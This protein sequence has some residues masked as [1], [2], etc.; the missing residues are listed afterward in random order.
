MQV[1]IDTEKYP[2][3]A[4]RFGVEALPTLMLFR[5]GKPVDRIVSP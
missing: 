4:S 5:N 3:L 1:K 2:K